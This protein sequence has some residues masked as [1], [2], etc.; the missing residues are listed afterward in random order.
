VS[1]GRFCRHG[2]HG[3]HPKPTKLSFALSE[4]ASVS[5][6]IVSASSGKRAAG[7]TMSGHSGANRVAVAARKLKSGRYKVTLLATDSTGQRSSPVSAS[8]KVR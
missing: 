2:A 6:K 7:V 3:C 8:F 1:G 5:M 4:D